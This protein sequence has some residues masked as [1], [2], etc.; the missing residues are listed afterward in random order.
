MGANDPHEPFQNILAGTR[1]LKELERDYGFNHKEALVAYNMGPT[2]AKR[3][4]SQYSPDE[5]L[6][7]QKVMHVYSVLDSADSQQIASTNGEP[8]IRA[9]GMLTK[10]KTLSMNDVPDN[11][12]N[13][14]KVELAKK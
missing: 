7:V 12:G 13:N 3:W 8:E 6:Y 11:L 9:T 4:L 10:P 1:Y 14:R 5:S 2:R